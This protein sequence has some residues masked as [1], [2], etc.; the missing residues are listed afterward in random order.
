MVWLYFLALALAGVSFQDV[1]SA[2]P[3][4]YVNN[5]ADIEG[6]GKTVQKP[7]KT[8]Q[9]CVNELRKGKGNVSLI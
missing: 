2:C 3:K 5:A 9:K 1:N 8:I 6:D 4:Y 7:F